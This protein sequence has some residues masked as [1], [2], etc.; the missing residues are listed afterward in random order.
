MFLV[1]SKHA[2]NSTALVETVTHDRDFGFIHVPQRSSLWPR[3]LIM[4]TESR[5]KE[6]A[7]TLDGK[8]QTY[9][10]WTVHLPTSLKLLGI[11]ESK[12]H[13]DIPSKARNKFLE[14]KRSTM[15]KE[16]HSWNREAKQTTLSSPCLIDLGTSGA[17]HFGLR[18]Q[19]RENSVAS[20]DGGSK[21]P[22]VW[23]YDLRGA[24]VVTVSVA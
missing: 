21:H 15:K 3:T 12:E 5:H 24:M 8:T 16:A 11:Q 10:P 7:S 4:L 17:S 19:M 9:N 22:S 13:W 18:P 23:P 1:L 2:N 20:W 14:L 6:A